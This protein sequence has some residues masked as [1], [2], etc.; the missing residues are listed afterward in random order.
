MNNKFWAVDKPLIQANHINANCVIKM[1]L[2]QN[3]EE[4]KCPVEFKVDTSPM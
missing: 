4:N 3:T 1:F 2:S